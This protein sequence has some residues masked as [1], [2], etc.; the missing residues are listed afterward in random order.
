MSLKTIEFQDTYWSGENNLIDEFYVPCLKQSVE[1]DRAVGYFSSSILC[2]IA[3]GLYN[4]ISNGGRMRIIC[5]VNISEQDQKDIELG[6]DIR[7]KISN[8]LDD[9]V[10]RFLSVNII[11]VKNLC[12]LI[13]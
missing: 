12:W 4:F 11:N 6:Y 9:E 7:D 1:Y 2:Y 8:I 10:D 13:K 3:N 5:S